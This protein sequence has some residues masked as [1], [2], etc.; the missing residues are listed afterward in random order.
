[1]GRGFYYIYSP[2]WCVT[3]CLKDVASVC[4]FLKWTLGGFRFTSPGFN[5]P[6]NACG[7]QSGSHVDFQP[8]IAEWEL[9]SHVRAYPRTE[10]SVNTLRP[11]CKKY[12]IILIKHLLAVYWQ[13][14]LQDKWGWHVKCHVNM[15]TLKKHKIVVTTVGSYAFGG[16]AYDT[17][18]TSY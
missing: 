17:S 12:F 6:D 14:S 3:A 1:M 18:Y 15:V 5:Y 16:L 8:V 7:A 13:S 4:N 11:D 2:C 9:N 10:V